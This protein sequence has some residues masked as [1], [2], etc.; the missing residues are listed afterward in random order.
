MVNWIPGK[1]GSYF[2][3]VED[4]IPFDTDEKIRSVDRIIEVAEKLSSRS[5]YY[6]Y[7]TDKFSKVECETSLI[8]GIR[9]P[10]TGLT[11][12]VAP[13]LLVLDYLFGRTETKTYYVCAELFD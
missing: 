8:G 6:K 5:I 2:V 4:V 10:G 3:N 1:K 7:V 9:T 12:E 11:V 13:T